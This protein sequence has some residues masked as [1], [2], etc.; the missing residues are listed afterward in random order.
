MLGVA[1]LNPVLALVP[2][3]MLSAFESCS[4]EGGIAW[5][6]INKAA[7]ILLQKVRC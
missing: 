2:T 3:E 7:L 1:V 4:E 6:K 5:L